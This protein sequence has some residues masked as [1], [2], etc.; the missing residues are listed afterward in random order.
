MHKYDGANVALC[1][2]MFRQV[3]RQYH[4][5]EFLDQ[6]SSRWVMPPGYRGSTGGNCPWSDREKAGSV[7]CIESKKPSGQVCRL[8]GSLKN[9]AP[10][11]RKERR[12][13]WTQN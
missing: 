9:V 10:P 5:V 11:V 12:G 13:V 8:I 3:G 4:A 2:A 7:I 6:V 1:Q